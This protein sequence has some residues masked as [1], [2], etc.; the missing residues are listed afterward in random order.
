LPSPIRFIIVMG[1]SGCGKTTVGRLLSRRLDWGFYD[2]DDYHPIENITKMENGIPL[3]DSDREPWLDGLH[4]LI[5]NCL[6]E[7]QPGV[8]AC[9]AL[10]Q[11]YR[12]LLTKGDSQILVVYLKGSFDMIWSRMEER[13]D[14]YMKPHMLRSQ[15]EALEEPMDALVVEIGK[16]PVEIC[17]EILSKIQPVD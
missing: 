6:R 14:H 11:K 9:S 13:I 5:T 4:H 2:A 16:T 10:K 7:N 8:L 1:V 15:F 3:T 17:D 12:D